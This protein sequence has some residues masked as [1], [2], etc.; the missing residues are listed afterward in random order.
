MNSLLVSDPFPE[1]KS[2]LPVSIIGRRY[3]DPLKCEPRAK[4]D[5]P[6]TVRREKTKTPTREKQKK[7]TQTSTDMLR[8]GQKHSLSRSKRATSKH[9]SKPV[10]FHQFTLIILIL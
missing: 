6:S 2:S 3:G 7:D 9:A 5:D 4:I 10:G 1:P 8:P